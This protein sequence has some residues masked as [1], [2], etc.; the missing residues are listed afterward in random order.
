M[1]GAAFGIGLNYY[2]ILLGV[3]ISIVGYEGY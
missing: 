2:A 1:G 3:G